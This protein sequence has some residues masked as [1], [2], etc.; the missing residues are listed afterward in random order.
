MTRILLSSAAAI[1]LAACAFTAS[2]Q[3]DDDEPPPP[4]SMTSQGPVQQA[5]QAAEPAIAWDAKRL[6]RLDRDLRRV[7]NELARLQPDKAPPQLI[8]PDPEV[9]TLQGRVDELTQRVQDLESA[10][11]RVNNSLD[12]LGLAVEGLKR[13]DAAAHADADALRQ[14]VTDLENQVKALTPPP[15]PPGPNGEPGAAGAAPAAS[16]PG[17]AFQAAMQQMRDGDYSSAAKAFQNYLATWPDGP[18]APEAHYRLAETYYVG[19]NQKSAAEEYARSLKGWP[20]VAWAPDANVKLAMALHNLGRSPDACGALV[21][22]RK[23]Y[24]ESAPATVKAR[25]EALET[26]A[27]CRAPTKPAASPTHH[28]RKR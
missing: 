10:L 5:G 9:T 28:H 27:E 24:A 26:K 4:P 18:D 19:D 7:R 25:A 22:F 6:Q 1:A 11:K 20:H 2:A 17:P 21:E 12:T 16:D 8:E 23:R 15:P 14:R 3:V 13:D